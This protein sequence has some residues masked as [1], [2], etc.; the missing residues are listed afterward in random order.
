MEPVGLDTHTVTQFL[1]LATKHPLNSSFPSSK[2]AKL[3]K[4]IMQLGKADIHVD[5]RNYMPTFL[6]H[7]RRLLMMMMIN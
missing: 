3:K 4:S 6:Q 1:M 2:M 5:K 7:S